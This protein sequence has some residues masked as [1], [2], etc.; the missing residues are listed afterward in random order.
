MKAIISCIEDVSTSTEIKRFCL[1]F[2]QRFVVYVTEEDFSNIE[3]FDLTDFDTK[4]LGVDNRND[5]NRI[6]LTLIKHYDPLV[7]PE[8]AHMLLDIFYTLLSL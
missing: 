4:H 1:K 5:W 6:I 2:F 8:F 7:E 3:G